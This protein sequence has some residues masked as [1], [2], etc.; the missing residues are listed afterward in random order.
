[1]ANAGADTINTIK[2]AREFGI[3]QGG[4]T[5]VAL[6]LFLT[7]IKSVGLDA[8]QGMVLRTASTGI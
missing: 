2:Q 4:Q 8:A 6:L 3:T 7:D 1:M 5:L